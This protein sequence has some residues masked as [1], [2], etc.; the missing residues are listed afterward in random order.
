MNSG[1]LLIHTQ[2]DKVLVVFAYFF[3][4]SQ[5][6]QLPGSF[7]TRV[8]HVSPLLFFFQDPTVLLEASQT[9]GAK[10][11]DVTVGWKDDRIFHIFPITDPWDEQYIY[12]HVQSIKIN[13][14][15]VGKYTI[16]PWILWVWTCFF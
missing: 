13:Q 15:H 5:R 2:S 3:S 10:E 11:T 6:T 16:V 8:G 4:I 1:F 14:D 9:L 12:L 7:S